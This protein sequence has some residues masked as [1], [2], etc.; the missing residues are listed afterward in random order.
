[1]AT[2]ASLTLILFP[3]GRKRLLPSLCDHACHTQ[4]FVPEARL[5]GEEI[6][7]ILRRGAGQIDPAATQQP[8][9]SSSLRLPFR[10]FQIRRVRGP[11]RESLERFSGDGTSPTTIIPPGVASKN[12]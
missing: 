11:E 7:A 2:A 1:M 9:S 10:D 6:A 4:E 8:G 5:D 3:R 12:Q